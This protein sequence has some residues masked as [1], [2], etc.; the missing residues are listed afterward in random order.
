MPLEIERKFLVTGNAWRQPGSA[1]RLRQGYLS[2]DPERSVR[3]RLAGT[4]AWLTIK[5]P[6]DGTTRL[7]YEYAIPV[8][9]AVELL[10]R[11]CIPPFIE[12]V[13]YRV[14]HA[15]LVWEV[16]EFEGDNAGLVLAEVELSDPDQA[17]VLPDWVG[18]EVTG[19]KRYYNVSLVKN[20][21]RSWS[22]N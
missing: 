10:E 1:T 13:R 16:D 6:S 7:E 11:L 21:Y 5:G 17:V 9:H 3:V 15:G 14:E 12:K 2:F 20:P 19:D 22:E 4:R 18:E 8:Q